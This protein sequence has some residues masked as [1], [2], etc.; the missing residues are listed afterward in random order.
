MTDVAAA[1]TGD[2]DW[3]IPM[4]ADIDGTPE[5]PIPGDGVG[6]V[7]IGTPGDCVDVTVA[8]RVLVAPAGLRLPGPFRLPPAAIRGTII[9]VIYNVSELKIGVAYSINFC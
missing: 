6:V 3:V 2:E 1:T 5:E 7:I 4:P 8:I 9:S